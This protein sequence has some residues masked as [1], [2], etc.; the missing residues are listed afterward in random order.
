MT[1]VEP[2]SCDLPIF[3]YGHRATSP[4][5]TRAAWIDQ[6]S[7]QS[8]GNPTLGTLTLSDG[9]TF[10]K[11]NLSF[12]W[13]DCS[14]YLAAP[15][16]HRMFGLF[17]TT[18]MAIVDC[19]DRVIWLARPA[20]GWLQPESFKN[21]VLVASRHFRQNG[22]TMRWEIPTCFEDMVRVAY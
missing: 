1:G 10:P 4:D 15:K 11:C 16:Y 5:G 19:D 9:L 14:R 17:L 13:S 20:H 18:K 7:E 22:R 6:A 21:G 2:S 12:L 8:M 3:R